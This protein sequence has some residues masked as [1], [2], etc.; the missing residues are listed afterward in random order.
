M[1]NFARSI[2]VKVKEVA[3]AQKKKIVAFGIM[4]SVSAYMA[5]PMFAAPATGDTDVD[6]ILTAIDVWWAVLKAGF[7]Y[8]ALAAIVITGFVLA[9]FWLRGKLKQAVSG[10]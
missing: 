9:F 7:K 4:S 5:L 1:V 8:L 10:A 6:A 3:A 2:G